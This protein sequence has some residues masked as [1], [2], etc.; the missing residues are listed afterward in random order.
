MNASEPDDSE[1]IVTDFPEFIQY[2]AVFRFQRGYGLYTPI[3]DVYGKIPI[4]F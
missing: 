3:F 2:V 4:C 1:L